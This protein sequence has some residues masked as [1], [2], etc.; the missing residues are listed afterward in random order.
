[1]K[2]RLITIHSFKSKIHAVWL[3]LIGRAVGVAEII[4]DGEFYKTTREVDE[5]MRDSSASC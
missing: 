4:P 1:M 3:V 5:L 2:L